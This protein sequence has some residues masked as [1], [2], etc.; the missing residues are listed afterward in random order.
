MPST[1]IPSA[2]KVAELLGRIGPLFRG[3]AE[4]KVGPPRKG[5]HVLATA[6]AAVL[7][8]GLADNG[9][10]AGLLG[11]FGPAP[12]YLWANCYGSINGNNSTFCFAF[13]YQG[14]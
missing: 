4:A 12:E 11:D 10:A 6:G 13:S 14:A 2:S 9:L 1:Q 7:E 8:A 3:E 5:H